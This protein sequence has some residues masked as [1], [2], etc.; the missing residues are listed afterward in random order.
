MR[1]LKILQHTL[2]LVLRAVVERHQ[3]PQ[4]RGLLVQNYGVFAA[5]MPLHVTLVSEHAGGHARA[6]QM[7]EESAHLCRVGIGR[8]HGGVARRGLGFRGLDLRRLRRS[9]AKGS[10]HCGSWQR[11]RRGYWHGHGRCWFRS[12]WVSRGSYCAMQDDDIAGLRWLHELAFGMRQRER[13]THLRE[14]QATDQKA[15]AHH[16]SGHRMLQR[17]WPPKLEDCASG[18][19]AVPRNVDHYVAELERDDVAFYAFTR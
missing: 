18:C 6:A 11:G 4:L 3:A 5:R 15:I 9:D 1:W 14:S 10:R 2:G 16:L 8:R 19:A 13:A 17:E 12:H 7:L